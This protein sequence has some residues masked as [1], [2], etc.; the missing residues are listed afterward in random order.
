M[1]EGCEVAG[2][3]PEAALDAARHC[4]ER[5]EIGPGPPGDAPILVADGVLTPLLRDGGL[6]GILAG[7]QQPAV[8]DQAVEL[9]DGAV[10]RPPEVAVV[11]AEPRGDRHLQH[12]RGQP[13]PAHAD[14]AARLAGTPAPRVG[15][16][17]D[18]AGSCRAGPT[19]GAFQRISQL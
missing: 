11:D 13:Q 19:G 8:L 2:S 4:L 17:D 12:R 6:P 10:L 5:L 9:A 14:T 7:R 18:P 16:R 3:P 1:P 15:E